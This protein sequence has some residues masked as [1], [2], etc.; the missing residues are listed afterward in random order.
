[1]T[2][3]EQ[4]E[5]EA[6]DEDETGLSR[7]ELFVKGGLL[8]AGAAFLG[9]PVAAARAAAKSPATVEAGSGFAVVT[10]GAGDAF[11]AVVKKGV[12]KAGKDLGVK[13]TYSESFNNPQ[14]QAQLIGTAVARKPAGNVAAAPKPRAPQ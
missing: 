9:S 5:W 3:H 11:W 12:L 2:E 13:V 7:R 14:K 6:I 1:M 4:V 10:H 8:T